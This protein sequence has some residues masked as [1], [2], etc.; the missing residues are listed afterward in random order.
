VEFRLCTELRDDDLVENRDE[1]L[2]E[3]VRDT[4]LRD[5]VR[6]SEFRDD[7]RE[8]VLRE[9]VRDTVLREGVR[10]MAP[11]EDDLETVLLGEDRLEFRREDVREEG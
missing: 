10:V 5:D 8:A 3:G 2:R 1:L 9:G 6:K 7:V 4:V 11:R